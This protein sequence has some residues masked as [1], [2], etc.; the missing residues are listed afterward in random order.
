MAYISCY[1][2]GQMNM[3]GDIHVSHLATIGRRLESETILSLVLQYTSCLALGIVAEEIVANS[4][5]QRNRNLAVRLCILEG[6]P[7]K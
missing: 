3:V 2:V 7:V 5:S 6:T 1:I 4:E